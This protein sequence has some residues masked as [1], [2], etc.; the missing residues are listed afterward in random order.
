MNRNTCSTETNHSPSSRLLPEGYSCS[1]R[2]FSSSLGDWLAAVIVAL[3]VLLLGACRGTPTP[4]LQPIPTATYI[5]TEEATPEPSAVPTSAPI[6]AVVTDTLRVR[7]LPSTSA[8]ILGRLRKDTQVTLMVRTDDNAWYGI[9]YPPQSGEHG[10]ISSAIVIPDQPTENLPVGFTL[11]PPPPGSI[12]ASVKHLLNVRSGP[13]K[14]YDIIGTLPAG[15]RIT[16]LARSEN[17]KWYQIF[18][19]PDTQRRAWALGEEGLLELQDQP[20]NL[21][22]APAPPTPTPAPTP[23]PRPTRTPGAS[24]AGAGRILVSSNRG[25]S[26]DIYSLADN[27]E[28]RAQLTHTGEAFGARFSPDGNRIVFYHTVT[29]SPV[30]TGHI[31]IMNADGKGLRDLSGSA[32]GA[33]DSDPD[34]S[35]DGSRIVFVRT[36][37]ARP[38]EIWVMNADGSGARRLLSLSPGT[39]VSGMS[40]GDFSP[41]PRW[42]PDGGRIAYA[43]VPRA[44][45]PG[46][47]LYPSIFVVN[48]DGSNETQLTDNDS[49][50]SN[51]VWSPD[52][53]QIAW[54]AKD[55]INRQ[56]WRVWMMNSSGGNQHIAIGGLGGDG[57]NAIQPVEWIGNRILLSGWTGN[58]DAYLANADGSKLTRVT[59]SSGDDRPTDWLP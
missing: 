48:A 37:R 41:H 32:G 30:A 53:K 21:P 57:A 59:T 13:S 18:Y 17:Q 38:P 26:Y 55:F 16:L 5:P 28:V 27:G 51:P 54:A 1:R 9:E 31:Y 24:G 15:I 7:E 47:P 33:S 19:P 52:G 49:I 4:T 2:V 58:W 34:W 42:S 14:D 56:N 12:F 22:V 40:A 39:G 25:G 44:E 3:L 35:P 50:N 29:T 23:V 43:A 6:S 10:W 45:N 8:R 36:P 11:P 46:A 20:D